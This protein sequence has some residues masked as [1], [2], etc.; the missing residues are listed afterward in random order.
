MNCSWCATLNLNG[1]MVSGC[2]VGVMGRVRVQPRVLET[3]GY[4]TG[5]VEYISNKR[6]YDYKDY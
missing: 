3:P 5:I 4:E 1:V 2:R 6:C